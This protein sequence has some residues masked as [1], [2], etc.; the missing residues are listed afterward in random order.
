MRA[1]GHFL[2]RQKTKC[3]Q[4]ACIKKLGCS[5]G[6][7]GFFHLIRKRMLLPPRMQS[8][9]DLL[10]DFLGNIRFKFE[11]AVSHNAEDIFL[12]SFPLCRIVDTAQTDTD[13]AERVRLPRRNDRHM[14]TCTGSARAHTNIPDQ[15]A[16]R[17]AVH[18]AFQGLLQVRSRIGRK[19]ILRALLPGRMPAAFC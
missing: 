3:L 19:E 13:Y 8:G 5:P 4:S 9:A 14:Q 11:L 17:Q 1:A 18:P 6:G 12:L 7:K 10:P 15:P 2:S 16:V